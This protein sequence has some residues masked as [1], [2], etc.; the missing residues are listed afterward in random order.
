[1]SRYNDRQRAQDA[2]SGKKHKGRR[3]L[4][5]YTNVKRSTAYHGLSTKAR[6]LLFELIDR[7]TGVNNGFIGLGVRE[8]RYELGMSAGSISAAMSELDDSGLARPMTPGAWRGK[9]ATEWRLMFLRCNKTQEPAVTV[10]EQ[11]ESHREF[12]QRNTK[13]Q[14]AERR[15][16]LSSAIGTQKPNS[17]M[18]GESLSSATGTHIHIYQGAGGEALHDQDGVILDESLPEPESNQWCPDNVAIFP[19]PKNLKNGGKP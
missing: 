15:D 7:Y 6:A 14:L 3:F 18:N 12:S 11:R 17:S 9:K 2:R 19:N 10:W 5:L 4:Q 13:V 16:S 8:A 1:M